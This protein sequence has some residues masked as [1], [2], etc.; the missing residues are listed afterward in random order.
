VP[1]PLALALT[2]TVEVP[3][4]VGTFVLGGL[5][6]PSVRGVAAAVAVTIGVN[7]ATHPLVWL[8]LKGAGTD[9]WTRFVAV[10]VGAWLAESLLLFSWVRRDV[11]LILLAALMANAASCLAGMLS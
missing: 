1:Y 5:V 8:V 11:R 7:L 6:R 10:E 3:L 4:L 9:Y 2:L